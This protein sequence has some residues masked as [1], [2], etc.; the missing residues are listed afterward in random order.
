VKLFFSFV[1]I[2]MLLKTNVFSDKARYCKKGH[3][4]N[5]VE[6]WLHVFEKTLPGP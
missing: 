5:L 2:L 4:L 1:Q 3:S 6:Q